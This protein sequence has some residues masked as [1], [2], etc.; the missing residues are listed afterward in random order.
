MFI[1]PKDQQKIDD[2]RLLASYLIE[3]LVS[4]MQRVKMHDAYQDIMTEFKEF[5]FGMRGNLQEGL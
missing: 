4:E 3:N 1:L 5:N 2:Q